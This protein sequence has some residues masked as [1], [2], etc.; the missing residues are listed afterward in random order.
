MKKLVI[1]GVALALTTA[2][3]AGS[4]TIPKQFQGNW[5]T[6]GGDEYQRVTSVKDCDGS[7]IEV[8]TTGFDTHEEMGCHLREIACLS[9]VICLASFQCSGDR[10]T[11]SMRYTMS[12]NRGRLV[13]TEVQK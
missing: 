9:D 7:P 6:H 3:Q 5:C 11:W 10:S 13:M 2:A 1:A 8:H 4:A 12:L